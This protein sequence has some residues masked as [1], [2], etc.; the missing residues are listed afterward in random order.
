MK[1]SCTLKKIDINDNIINL[2]TDKGNFKIEIKKGC[3]SIPIV[4]KSK[5]HMGL[6]S[7]NL[8]D[9]I[10]IYHNNNNVNKIIIDETYDFIDSESD[11]DI[12]LSDEL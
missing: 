3:C 5:E 9:N 4:S 8:N 6:M 11:N 10:L 1:V 7:L 12:L 2:E